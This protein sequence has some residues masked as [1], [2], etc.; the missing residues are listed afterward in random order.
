MSATL[1][2][3]ARLA[4]S[5]LGQQ[6]IA[7]IA[8]GVRASL[9]CAEHDRLDTD[10][11]MTAM[12]GRVMPFLDPLGRPS[13]PSIEVAGPHDFLLRLPDHHAPE[14]TRVLIAAGA[15]GYLLHFAF[16][17]AHHAPTGP[18]AAPA[19]RMHWEASAFAAHL[20]VPR[21][22]LAAQETQTPGV[23]ARRFDVPPAVIAARLDSLTPAL[24]VDGHQ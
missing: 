15:G 22:R 10:A 21:D 19:Y 3:H 13:G 16:P 6:A 23:L 14:R 1:I 18:W 24:T 12:G 17:R 5:G 2:R 7:R 9:A 11:L 20:L 4:P 8:D